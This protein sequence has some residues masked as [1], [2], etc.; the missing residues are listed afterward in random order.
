MMERK[1]VLSLEKGSLANPCY[2]DSRFSEARRDYLGGAYA[3]RS[4]VALRLA[5]LLLVIDSVVPRFVWQTLCGRIPG[6]FYTAYELE[7]WVEFVT[8]QYETV[9]QSTVIDAKRMFLK[10]LSD[11]PYRNCVFHSTRRIEDPFH[12]VTEHVSLGIYDQG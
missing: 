2:V 4:V 3:V 12:M 1:Q 10:I 8:A 7:D 9:S 11:L 5:A 6:C